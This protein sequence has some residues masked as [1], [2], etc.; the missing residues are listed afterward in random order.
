VPPQRLA[1][2]A[3][4]LDARICR[5]HIEDGADHDFDARD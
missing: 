4:E 1:G 2:L 3:G 5:L